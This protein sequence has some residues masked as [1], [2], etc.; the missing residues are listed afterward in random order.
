MFKLIAHTGEWTELYVSDRASSEVHDFM[1]PTSTFVGEHGGVVVSEIAHLDLGSDKRPRV[2]TLI[3]DATDALASVNIQTYLHLRL[4]DEFER[5][6]AEP[7]F[8]AKSVEFRRIFHVCKQLDAQIPRPAEVPNVPP[9]RSAPPIWA[10][11]PTLAAFVLAVFGIY[12]AMLADG[13]RDAAE[14]AAV[15]AMKASTMAGNRKANTELLVDEHVS[16]LN[17]TIQRHMNEIGT[18]S[19]NLQQQK[20]EIV[21]LQQDL[22]NRDKSLRVL[23][24]QAETLENRLNDTLQETR[25]ILA[26]IRRRDSTVLSRDKPGVGSEETHPSRVEWSRTSLPNLMSRRMRFL[27]PKKRTLTTRARAA[28]AWMKHHQ[29]MAHA[30]KPR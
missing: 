27:V 4:T 8:D 22:T 3:V 6:I 9:A 2:V 13:H 16:R 11:A 5:L 20:T 29:Q 24:L 21:G 15:S 28:K 14:A 17:T 23:L 1:P 30:K 26:E 7:G 25:T 18:E 19:T 12:F 10:W